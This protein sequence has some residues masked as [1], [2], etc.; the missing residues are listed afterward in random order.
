MLRFNQ[1]LN[2]KL[3]P[4]IVF[5]KMCD[6]DINVSNLRCNFARTVAVFNE[7]SAVASL[8]ICGKKER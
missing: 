2:N 6:S 1:Y 7:N 4:S 8:D 5:V 3:T